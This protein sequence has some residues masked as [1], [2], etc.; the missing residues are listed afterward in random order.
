MPPHRNDAGA[1]MDSAIGGA[2]LSARSASGFG[3]LVAAAGMR[4]HH[5]PRRRLAIRASVMHWQGL[6]LLVNR[7]DAEVVARRVA[8][9]GS[10]SPLI[11]A[12]RIAVILV[13]ESPFSG[14][15]CAAGLAMLEVQCDRHALSFGPSVQRGA[16]RGFGFV[17]LRHTT[18]LPDECPHLKDQEG[19][20]RKIFYSGRVRVRR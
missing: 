14:E 11:T 19:G 8:I 17:H 13:A 3:L 9:A 6:I 4:R 7:V 12:R 2:G 10:D 1:V 18:I 5:A 16:G 15:L 20:R